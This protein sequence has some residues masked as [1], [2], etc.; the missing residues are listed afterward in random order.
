MPKDREFDELVYLRNENR[1]LRKSLHSLT[2]PLDVLL[3]RRGFKVF[4]QNQRKICCC[5]Q[6]SSWMSITECSIGI[7]SDFFSAMSLNIRIFFRQKM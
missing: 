2:V 3:K 7:H 4:K 6:M 1:R 5:L